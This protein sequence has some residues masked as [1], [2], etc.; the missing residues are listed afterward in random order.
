MPAQEGNYL[1]RFFEDLDLPAGIVDENGSVV[2]ANRTA[3]EGFSDQSKER[4]AAHE[5]L[6]KIASW[7]RSTG[8][9]WRGVLFET[10][11]LQ[12]IVRAWP[13]GESSVAFLGWPTQQPPSETTRLVTALG[14]E[15]SEARLALRIAHGLTD[16]AIGDRLGVA[17]PTIKNRTCTLYRKLGVRNRVELTALVLSSLSEIEEAPCKL[18]RPA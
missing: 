9:D 4:T 6:L 2:F 5:A 16:E 17:L 13:L 3:R 8:R 11:E 7:I 18:A 10:H 15:P 12:W 14:L 1:I